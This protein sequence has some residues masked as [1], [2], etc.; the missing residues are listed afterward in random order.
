MCIRD[1]GHRSQHLKDLI[2]AE[3]PN[4]RISRVDSAFDSLSGTLEFRRVASWL[5]DRAKKAGMNTRWIKNSDESIG[6]TLYVG[7][8][9]SRVMI[10][11]YE[12]G[13]EQK[14]SGERRDLWWRAEVQ[15]RPDTKAKGAV[16]DWSSGMIWG[17]SN[18]TRDFMVFLTGEKI[19]ANNL[20]VKDMKKDLDTRAAWMLKQ[21]GNVIRDLVRETGSPLAMLSKLEMLSHDL[22]LPQIFPVD[23][24]E[25]RGEE[26]AIK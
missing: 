24:G 2:V 10:R 18:L 22:G 5:E 15:L 7:S 11:L 25:D 26:L 6:D 3:F 23:A 16:Y 13:K 4:G 12:K 21:Y 14:L 8:P 19:A 20:Q 1:R 17:A 9:S